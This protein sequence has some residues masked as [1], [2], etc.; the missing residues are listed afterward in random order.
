MVREGVGRGGEG[1][2][3]GER[4]RGGDEDASE[5]GS[6]PRKKRKQDAY[7][8]AQECKKKRKKKK[9]NSYAVSFATG[10][11]TSTQT[12]SHTQC[13]SVSARHTGC[14]SRADRCHTESMQTGIRR[15]SDLLPR[16][17]RPPLISSHRVHANLPNE[18]EDTHTRGRDPYTVQ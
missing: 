7:Q 18:R 9:I 1:R 16:R 3:D 4:E 11:A 14:V 17:R 5:F 8:V 15:A 10:T 2:K 12:R 13:H 6:R